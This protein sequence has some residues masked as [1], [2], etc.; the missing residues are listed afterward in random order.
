MTRNLVK[1]CSLLVAGVLVAT[2]P[3]VALVGC[4]RDAD[5]GVAVSGQAGKGKWPLS[6]IGEG[7]IRC[8]P[9]SRWVVFESPDG[10]L[11]AVNGSASFLVSQGQAAPLEDVMVEPRLWADGP[12][13]VRQ[14]WVN[15]GMALCKGDV[16][17]ARELA[18]KANAL[19]AEP[20]SADVEVELSTEPDDVK[21]RQLY[22]V[23]RGCISQEYAAWYAKHGQGV[24]SPLPPDE[25]I[26]RA[27]AV[28][29]QLTEEEADTLWLE[30]VTKVW[31]KP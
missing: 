20:I 12:A 31:P 28:K 1:R 3:L 9:D 21:R 22:F 19:A 17:K 18:T 6:I 30:G 26:G 11:Y 15:A 25:K 23:Y 8:W 24:D 2:G 14:Q 16:A 4:G 29:L 7:L 10:R 5:S 13:Q 27:C